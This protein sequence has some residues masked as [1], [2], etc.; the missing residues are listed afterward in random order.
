MKLLL[1]KQAEKIW[2]TR[3]HIPETDSSDIKHGG[4]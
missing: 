4:T 1:I 3:I 2:L